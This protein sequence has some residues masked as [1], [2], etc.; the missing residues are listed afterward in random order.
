MIFLALLEEDF[1]KKVPSKVVAPEV[2][3]HR[4][5]QTARSDLRISSYSKNT[6]H[7][8]V[9]TVRRKITAISGPFG[10]PGQVFCG[11]MAL[12]ASHLA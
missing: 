11:R 4:R 8:S 12:T 2:S 9:T 1:S 7:V 5:P 6:E 10:H 3:F